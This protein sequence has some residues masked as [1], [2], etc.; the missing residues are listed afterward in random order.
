MRLAPEVFWRFTLLEWH[1]AIEGYLQSKGVGS[2]DALTG[3]ELDEL[4]EE[5]P[6]G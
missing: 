6:D 2:L 5:Y 4:M 3:D 1:D